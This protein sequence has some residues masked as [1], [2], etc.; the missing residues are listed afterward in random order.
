MID[1]VT[2]KVKNLEKSKQFY[3]SIFDS[4]G[5]KLAF[6]DEGVFWAF[7]VGSGCLFE[8]MKYEDQASI[9]GCHVAIR[10]TS[11]EQV[12]LFH[13]LALDAGA[14]DNGKP[15]PRPQYTTGYY[16]AFIKDLD[17]HNIEMMFD[18]SSD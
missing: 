1:H 15:G 4:L 2:L 16:A 7:N 6:G 8:I 18:S 10:A 5:F 14:E 13:S 11:R 3:L 12:N 17:G 9:T